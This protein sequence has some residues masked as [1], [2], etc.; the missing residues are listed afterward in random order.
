VG[1]SKFGHFKA[2]IKRPKCNPIVK[3]EKFRKLNIV[4]EGV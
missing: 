2:P 3:D 4:N 1:F